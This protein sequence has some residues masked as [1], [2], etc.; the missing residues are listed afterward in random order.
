MGI[1][2]S[3]RN[4]YKSKDKN[5]VEHVNKLFTCNKKY[6]PSEMAI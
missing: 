5:G 4:S 1:T 3:I 2:T 6:K